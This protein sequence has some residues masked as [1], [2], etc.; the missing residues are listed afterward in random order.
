MR[1]DRGI[2]RRPRGEALPPMADEWMSTRELAA[3]IG[4]GPSVVNK[5][6]AAGEIPG[7]MRVPVNRGLANWY[8]PAS[9][10][11][12]WQ[13]ARRD[14]GRMGGRP[15]SGHG[16]YVVPPP[17]SEPSELLR[18]SELTLLV[19]LVDRGGQVTSDDGRASAELAALCPV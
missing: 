6:V 8:V 9:G 14:A 16:G 11:R 12:L 4:L 5:A 10:V 3:R 7:A 17:V 2:S 18:L 15:I 1:P 13:Q 19:T